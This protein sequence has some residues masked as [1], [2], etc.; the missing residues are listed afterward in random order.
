MTWTFHVIATNQRRTFSRILQVLDSQMVR[1]HS[2]SGNT[3][4]TETCV[5]VIFS[6]EQDKAYRIEALLH[7]LEDVHSVLISAYQ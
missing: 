7:R 6:S 1:I 3:N 4:G 2:F 5:T